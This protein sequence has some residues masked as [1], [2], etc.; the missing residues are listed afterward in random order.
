[1]VEREVEYS[2]AFVGLVANKWARLA[3]LVLVVLT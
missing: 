2:S 1:M 3:L